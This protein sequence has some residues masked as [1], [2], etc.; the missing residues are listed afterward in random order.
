MGGCSAPRS[1]EKNGTTHGERE[2]TS[3]SPRHPYTKDMRK[4]STLD[5]THPCANTPIHAQKDAPTKPPTET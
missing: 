2:G 5:F 3:H 1:K 4:S